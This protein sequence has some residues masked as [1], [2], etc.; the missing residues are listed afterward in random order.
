[1]G[2]PIKELFI[3]ASGVVG[4]PLLVFGLILSAFGSTMG[5]WVLVLGLV[6]VI[7]AI[8]SYVAE[9]NGIDDT[10]YTFITG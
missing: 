1:L 2:V 9:T 5:I 4:A 8:I 6:I 7:F 10:R 3:I